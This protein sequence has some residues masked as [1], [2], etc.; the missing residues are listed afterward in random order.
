MAEK[1]IEKRKRG[2]PRSANAETRNSTVL[3]LDRGLTVLQALAKASSA[4]LSDLAL[5][6]GMPPSTAHRI[7]ATLEKHQFV[8]FGRRNPNMGH[9]D[10]HLPRRQ[11]ISGTHQS[12]RSLQKSHA[13]PDGRNR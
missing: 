9:R 10:R 1:I 7:L 13:K 11:H 8:E 3:A 12:D 4:T 2:R 6:V 5:Q